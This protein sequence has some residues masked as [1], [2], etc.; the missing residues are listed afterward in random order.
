MRVGIGYDVHPLARGRKLTLGGVHIPHPMGLEGHSDADLLLH[1]LG[2]ALLGAA[3]KKD[4][5]SLFPDNDPKYKGISSLILLRRIFQLLKKNGYRINNVDATL[6][7]EE[8]K[9]LP[10]VDKMK[11]NIAQTLE[12]QTDRIG[13]KATTSERMGFLGKKKAICCWAVATIQRVNGSNS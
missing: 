8:P 12:I 7:T 1:S 2:D 11:E 6:V 13:I 4:M 9:I 5:G 3:G 10:Y